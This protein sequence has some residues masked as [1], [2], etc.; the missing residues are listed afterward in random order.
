MKEAK[1]GDLVLITGK[2]CEP[3]MAVAGGQKIPWD[4]RAAARRALAKIGYQK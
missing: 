4:D 2:G 1:A 3:V